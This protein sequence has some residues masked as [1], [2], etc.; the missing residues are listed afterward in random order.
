MLIPSVQGQI[1]DLRDLDPPSSL[2]D[3]VSAL[4]DDAQAA[5]D[6]GKADPSILTSQKTDPF[7]QVNKTAEDLGLTACGG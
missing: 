6:K 2:E 3:Q 7:K 5:L 4:L 1:D